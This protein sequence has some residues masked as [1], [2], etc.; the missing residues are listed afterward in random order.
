MKHKVF[1]QP[2]P[3][4]SNIDTSSFEAAKN[5]FQKLLLV[6]KIQHTDINKYLETGW[7]VPVDCTEI[8]KYIISGTLDDFINQYEELLKHE[9]EILS[10]Q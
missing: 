1:F 6:I 8:S 2:T 4:I 10:L 7:N 3:L 5:I 9:D